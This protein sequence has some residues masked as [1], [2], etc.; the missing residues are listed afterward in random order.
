MA[1]G[2]RPGTGCV[3]ALVEPPSGPI[4]YEDTFV[5]FAQRGGQSADPPAPAPV[6]KSAG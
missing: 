2:T 3:T 6:G 4:D 5:M 1:G